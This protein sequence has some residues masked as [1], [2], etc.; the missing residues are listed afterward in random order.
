VSNQPPIL[1]NKSRAME[2]SSRTALITGGGSGIDKATSL[3]LARE[4]RAIGI[5][6]I[7]EQTIAA[8]AQAIVAAGGTVFAVQA[9]V[10][11]RAQGRV[12]SKAD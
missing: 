7:D 11:D 5:L 12:C 1:T 4:G 2:Q 9:D 3:R 10:S 6:G 8:V